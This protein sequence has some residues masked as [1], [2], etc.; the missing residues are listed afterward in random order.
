[1]VDF[2]DISTKAGKK[3]GILRI[4]LLHSLKKKPKSGYELL[5]E[6]KEKTNGKWI[7]SKGAIYPLL[8]QLK[9]EGFIKIKSVDKR[10]KNIFE[11]TDSG[12]KA[13]SI[14]KK[15]GKQMEDQF[16][17]FRNLIGEIVSPKDKDITKLLFDI[18]LITFAKIKKD[19]DRVTNILMNCLT[20]L[21]KIPYNIEHSNGETL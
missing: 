4:Y 19:K 12:I 11:I 21:N 14:F 20:N 7:P 1:M 8:K 16:I 10:S 2:L 15:Q 17:Q 5:R 13:L 18:R 9:D 3:R 6:I